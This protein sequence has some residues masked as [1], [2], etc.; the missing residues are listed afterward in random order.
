MRRLIA[1]CS[2]VVLLA[3]VADAQWLQ[4]PDPRSPRT[5]DGRPDLSA[6]APTTP[7]GKPDLSGVWKAEITPVS[8]WRRKLGDA[9]ADEQVKT[10]IEGQGIGTISIYAM[11]VMLDIPPDEQRTL[12]RP[13]TAAQMRRPPDNVRAGACLP[14]GF[15]LAMLLMPVTKLIQAPN[16][17]VMLLEAENA[18]RQIYVDGRPLP[19][20]PQPSW[21]GYSA[22]RWD[23]DT[24][25]VETNGLNDKTRLDIAG[26]PRS[27]S[28]RMT[29][30]YHRR[31]FGH[32]D[33]E[34]TF[35]DPVYYTRPFSMKV[36]DVLQADTDILEYICEENEKDW[37]HIGAH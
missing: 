17:I 2:A 35:D 32:M 27:E 6:P 26:H 4:Y 15:P 1:V 13:A 11:N 8:E 20:D 24:L 37:T 10:R 25:V 7:D 33:V 3:G 9:A 34:I 19:R 12:L 21:F 36:T 5:A 30:R 23:G 18:Y 22:A 29:E 14:I 16:V 28:M 31:D